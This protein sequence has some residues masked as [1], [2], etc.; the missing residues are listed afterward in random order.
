MKE[1]F[2]PGLLFVGD[3]QMTGGGNTVVTAESYA[4]AGGNDGN[5]NQASNRMLADRITRLRGEGGEP[6]VYAVGNIEAVSYVDPNR[7]IRGVAE[8]IQD[9]PSTETNVSAEE[10]QQQ[11]S[12]KLNRFATLSDMNK[13]TFESLLNTEY[14]WLQSALKDPV[15]ADPLMLEILYNLGFGSDDYVVERG[16]IKVKNWERVKAKLSELRTI[17]ESARHAAA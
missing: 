17:R 10:L 14:T 12:A 3:A 4:L 8:Q 7:F 2:K 5:F 13:N 1:M 11:L 16:T 15:Q 9:T 6:N